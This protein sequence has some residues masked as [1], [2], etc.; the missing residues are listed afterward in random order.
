MSATPHS[1]ADALTYICEALGISLDWIHDTLAEAY[2]LDLIEGEEYLPGVLNNVMAPL[3]ALHRD[4]TDEC[5]RVGDYRRDDGQLYRP[6]T[7]SN[8]RDVYTNPT[9]GFP[10]LRLLNRPSGE[11][12]TSAVIRG[13]RAGNG[14]KDGVG[15]A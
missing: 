6:R 5:E 11:P 9:P 2:G 8:G 13:Q 4:V 14:M 7:Y 12:S 3:Y 1:A 10:N 15:R